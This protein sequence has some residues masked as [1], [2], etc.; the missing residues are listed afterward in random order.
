M[1]HL[2]YLVC[3]VEM[4]SYQLNT[5]DTNVLVREVPSESPQLKITSPFNEGARASSGMG[6]ARTAT[7]VRKE[8]ASM[9]DLII[10]I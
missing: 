3:I 6:A 10:N 4:I 7:C 1:F 5:K 8:T 9:R 2:A